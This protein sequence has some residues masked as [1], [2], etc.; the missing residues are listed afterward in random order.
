[1]LTIFFFKKENVQ[2]HN[3]YQI[4]LYIFNMLVAFV[5]VLYSLILESRAS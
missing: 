4:Y 2:N 5:A 1:M 3:K